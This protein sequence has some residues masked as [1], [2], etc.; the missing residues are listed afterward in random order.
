MA[1]ERHIQRLHTIQQN[2]IR[3]LN[4]TSER[5]ASYSKPQISISIYILYIYIYIYAHLYIYTCAHTYIHTY[6]YKDL[7]RKK[8]ILNRTNNKH[9]KGDWK[10]S[11]MN[12]SSFQESFC[13]KFNQQPV[14]SDVWF[15]SNFQSIQSNNQ[16]SNQSLQTAINFLLILQPIKSNN[17]WS[18]QSHLI[19]IYILWDS[20]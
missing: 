15:P 14:K 11:G 16:W 13:T 2:S 19:M 8:A 1:M 3:V 20:S 12:Y 6:I 7:E 9:S 5:I 18:N 10:N 17:Q 4:R